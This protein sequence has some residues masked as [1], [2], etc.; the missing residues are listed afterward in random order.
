MIAKCPELEMGKNSVNPCTTANKTTSHSAIL[1]HPFV[2]SLGCCADAE[3]E[4][5]QLLRPP[6]HPVKRLKATTVPV[7]DKIKDAFGQG[8]GHAGGVAHQKPR[9]H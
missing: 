7:G 4:A 1:R 8:E 9:H 2:V 3:E 6:C 5:P